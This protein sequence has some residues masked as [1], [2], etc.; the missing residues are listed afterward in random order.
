M[1]NIDLIIDTDNLNPYVT[2]RTYDGYYKS[3]TAKVIDNEFIFNE[4]FHIA[5]DKFGSIQFS[6]FDHDEYGS[7]DLLSGF[8]LPGVFFEQ[9]TGEFTQLAFKVTDIEG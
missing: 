3:L 1:S 9:Y 4:E 2:M 5:V 8:I 7:D 6:V